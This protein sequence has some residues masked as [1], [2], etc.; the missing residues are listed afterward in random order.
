MLRLKQGSVWIRRG[1]MTGILLAVG[2]GCLEKQYECSSNAECPAGYECVVYFPNGGGQ[3]SSSVCMTSGAQVPDGG[4][5][6]DPGALPDNGTHVDPGTPTDSGPATDLGTD[7]GPSCPQDKNCTGLACGLDPVCGLSCGECEGGWSCDAGQCVWGP[8]EYSVSCANGMCLVPEGSFM[9]G[10][11]EQ[12]DEDCSQSERPLRRVTVPAFEIDEHEVTVD[13]YKACVEAN[14]EGAKKCEIPEGTAG[15]NCNWHLDGMGDHPVNCI[16]WQQARDF[17][18]FAGKRL[19]T[20]SEWEKASRGTD[21]RK[22]PWGNQ[23]A[24]C[25]LAVMSESDQTSG[26]GCETGKTFVVASKPAGVSPYGLLDMSGNVSEWVE[27][28]WHNRYSEVAPLDGKA[29]VDSPRASFRVIRG[30]SY[31]NQ[32]A[33]IRSGYRNGVASTLAETK[34]G[35]RCCRTP[36]DTPEGE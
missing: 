19:C 10:C 33:V 9:Q 15:D 32:G 25:A 31:Q 30:G 35:V 28:D 17:C 24:T 18:E 3:H 34:L 21:G 26:Y 7:P 8:G 6:G 20:E 27:D 29:W 1:L 12:V 16:S 2:G 5:L 22:Y 23:I 13:Q 36:P 4:G 11:V 14:T